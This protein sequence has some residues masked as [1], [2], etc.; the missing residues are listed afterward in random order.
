M[1]ENDRYGA[2]IY[3]EFVQGLQKFPPNTIILKGGENIITHGRYEK[4]IQ[5]FGGKPQGKRPVLIFK[6]TRDHVI[7][8]GLKNCQCVKLIHVVEDF[9]DRRGSEALTTRHPSIHKSW[10]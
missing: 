8:W 9:N 10:H 6:C 2:I 3:R 5:N 1:R 4:C 7:K